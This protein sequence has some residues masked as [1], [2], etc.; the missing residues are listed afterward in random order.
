M[1]V[2]VANA[3]GSDYD[4][5]V[6][7]GYDSWI[8]YWNKNRYPKNDYKASRCRNC[9]TETNDLDGGHV[10]YCIRGNDGKWRYDKTKGV[11]ITPLCAE[12]NNPGNTKVFE[13]DNLDLIKAP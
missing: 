12:C 11:Y 1:K 7:Y 4:S 6:P 3:P 9:G 13:V 5:T 2:N 10:E 8:D